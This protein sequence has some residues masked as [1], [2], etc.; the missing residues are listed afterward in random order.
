M[1][2]AP[3]PSNESKR[4]QALDR[5]DLLDT[6]PE[7]A[8]NDISILAAQIC[9]TPIALISL[10]DRQRQ[11]FKAK[12]GLEADET[13]RA[14]A[15]CAHAILEPDNVF[16][17]SNALED[18][19]FADNPLVVEDPHLRFY[20]GAP[21]ITPD[22]HAVG[23]VCAIDREPRQL[24]PEQLRALQALS[25]QTVA[26]MELRRK[27][28]QLDDT[29]SRL[30]HTQASLIHAEKMSALGQFVAGIA[31]EINNPI[32]FIAGNLPHAHRYSEDLL[33]LITLYHQEYPDT[34]E[35]VLHKIEQIDLDYLTDDFPKLMNS[36]KSGADRI[37]QIVQSLKM[38]SHLDES[39]IKT[40][41][42]NANLDYTLEVVRHRFKTDGHRPE[43]EIVK[44]YGNIP[45]VRCAIGE[46]NQAFLNII[47][48]AIDAI[49][50]RPN[51]ANKAGKILIHTEYLNRKQPG[52]RIEISDN[53]VG[54]SENKKS[55][56]FEP[57]YTT[58]PVGQGTG[59][60]LSTT[61]KIIVEKHGGKL[62]FKSE[63]DRGTSFFIEIPDAQ[64]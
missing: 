32:S 1:L 21:L 12:F 23:T 47:T 48:N 22:G 56:I 46:I 61:Y 53:G 54:I 25:R 17:V 13:P 51:C 59:L 36:M 45:Q 43:I 34:S 7:D 18:E 20:A 26:Q 5:Y 63:V 9:G 60:G 57:F 55:K 37:Q 41:D 33:N 29:L 6:L 8:F 30:K 35:A 49:D 24:T 62:Y 14:I 15:F 39:E 52:I 44:A 40:V 58:K 50:E 16:V 3:H 28:A 4:Q 38:F 42:L 27:V 31:H 10:V 64:T 11:W 2:I 19:R